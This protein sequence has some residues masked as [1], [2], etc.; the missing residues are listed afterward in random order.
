MRLQ[1]PDVSNPQT[2][3]WYVWDASTDSRLGKSS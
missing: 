1:R 2:E 3:D